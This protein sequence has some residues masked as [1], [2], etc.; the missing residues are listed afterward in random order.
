MAALWWLL[1]PSQ[2]FKGNLHNSP[3]KMRTLRPVP[4]CSGV[5]ALVNLLSLGLLSY[6]LKLLQVLKFINL[7]K[8]A[9]CSYAFLAPTSKIPHLLQT[10]LGPTK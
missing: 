10:M 2:W 3:L 1:T 4:Q 7:E 8:N 5:H 9:T 6:F